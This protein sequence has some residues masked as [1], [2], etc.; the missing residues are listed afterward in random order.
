MPIFEFDKEALGGILPH[1]FPLLLLDAVTYDSSIPNKIS[2]ERLIAKDDIFLPGHFPGNPV[3]PGVLQMEMINQAAAAL[4]RI[5]F[6]EITSD[7]AVVVSGNAKFKGIVLPGD[8]LV[9]EAELKKNRENKFFVFDGK[10]TREGSIVCKLTDMM[11]TLQE[12]EK[13]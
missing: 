8:L 12:G 9:V 5:Q 4:I 6:P 13:K 10:I 2:A 11:G 1:R 3:Y 7:P